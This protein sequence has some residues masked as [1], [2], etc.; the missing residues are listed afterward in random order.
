MKQFYTVLAIST[1]GAPVLSCVRACPVEVVGLH[2]HENPHEFG[3]ERLRNTTAVNN[4]DVTA[5]LFVTK[6]RCVT[7][8]VELSLCFLFS[9]NSVRYLWVTSHQIVLEEA[10]YFT[11]FVQ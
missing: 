1:K 5:F 8:G 3:Y 10:D 6:A 2:P 11:Q 7:N 9:R 4:K